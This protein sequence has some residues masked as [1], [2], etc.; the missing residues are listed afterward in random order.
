MPAAAFLVK[1]PSHICSKKSHS[2]EIPLFILEHLLYLIVLSKVVESSVIPPSENNTLQ[3]DI[4][5]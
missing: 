3:L 1:I 2:Q 4:D 5:F